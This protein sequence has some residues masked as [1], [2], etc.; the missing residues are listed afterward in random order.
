V[1]W[2]TKGP[3]ALLQFDPL[4][5]YGGRLQSYYSTVLQPLANISRDLTSKAATWQLGLGG[6]QCCRLSAVT[7]L[8]APS[9]SS[10]GHSGAGARIAG[11]TLHLLHRRTSQS[12]SEHWEG[13]ARRRRAYVHHHQLPCRLCQG[14]GDAEEDQPGWA[15]LHGLHC[16][17]L[18]RI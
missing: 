7:G 2:L 4:A 18:V 6:C 9:A 8:C 15:A 5:D 12:C 1:R 3:S 13:P 16:Y 11:G 17:R 14:D 10:A